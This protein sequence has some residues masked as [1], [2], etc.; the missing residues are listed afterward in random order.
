MDHVIRE[1]IEIEPHPR[2]MI[3]ADGFCLSKSWK[4]LIYTWEKV[5]N[6]LSMI[7]HGGVLHQT[8]RPFWGHRSAWAFSAALSAAAGSFRWLSPQPLPPLIPH[9][10]ASL[11]TGPTYTSRWSL[12][13]FFFL[14]FFHLYTL[15]VLPFSGPAQVHFSLLLLVLSGPL[16]GPMSE[17]NSLLFLPV[18]CLAYS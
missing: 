8:I 16:Y 12:I 10:A 14:A 6:A 3:S 1:V 9:D 4:H 17:L 18:A 5:G 13:S 11:L 15:P 2:N 7:S